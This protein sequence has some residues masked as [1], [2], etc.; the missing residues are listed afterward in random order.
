MQRGFPDI[1]RF[2]I[3]EA[4]EVRNFSFFVSHFVSIFTFNFVRPN[5]GPLASKFGELYI[6]NSHPM[7]TYNTP[8]ISSLI[9]MEFCGIEFWAQMRPRPISE[10]LCG[11]KRARIFRGGDFA[12]LYKYNLNVQD[13]QLIKYVYMVVRFK[14]NKIVTKSHATCMCPGQFTF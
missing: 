1:S 2:F 10:T 8:G 6:Q 13:Y 14:D 5:F 12:Q 4:E 7:F 3:L 11:T 9:F